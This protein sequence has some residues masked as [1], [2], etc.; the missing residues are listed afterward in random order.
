MGNGFCFCNRERLN[1]SKS[2]KISQGRTGTGFGKVLWILWNQSRFFLD[3]CLFSHLET[4]QNRLVAT[5]EKFRDTEFQLSVCQSM[6]LWPVDPW[7]IPLN[8]S[9]DR[10]PKN[11]DRQPFI[12]LLQKSVYSRGSYQ[13]QYNGDRGNSLEIG[14]W[15]GKQPV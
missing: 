15:T 4:S 1:I 8:V 13:E 3:L 14:N 6:R 9:L 12:N 2:P 5:A 11:T 10:A 7:K